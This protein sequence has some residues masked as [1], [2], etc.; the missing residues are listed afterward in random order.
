MRDYWKSNLVCVMQFSDG[1]NDGVHTQFVHCDLTFIRH[2]G[3]VF[4]WLKGATFKVMT[5][6]VIVFVGQRSSL[7][8]EYQ[9]LKTVFDILVVTPSSKMS[10]FGV[11]KT[12]WWTWRCLWAEQFISFHPNPTAGRPGRLRN[13][14]LLLSLANLKKVSAPPPRKVMHE[15]PGARGP[16]F[17]RWNESMRWRS[18]DEKFRRNRLSLWVRKTEITSFV[19]FLVFSFTFPVAKCGFFLSSSRHANMYKFLEQLALLYPWDPVTNLIVRCNWTVVF[20]WLSEA[21]TLFW[22]PKAAPFTSNDTVT[23]KLHNGQLRKYMFCFLSL[24][25]RKTSFY[26]AT[27]GLL[28]QKICF[29]NESSFFFCN[30]EIFSFSSCILRLAGNRWAAACDLTMIEFHSCI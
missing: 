20:S 15:Y 9:R 21:Q 18:S 8:G 6:F 29:N 27:Y 1:S 2:L 3:L 11:Q 26:F 14:I 23:L 30:Q 13:L 22:P 25:V 28:K 7:C 17:A 4:C 12:W 19:W 10:M 24:F 16:G 5:V